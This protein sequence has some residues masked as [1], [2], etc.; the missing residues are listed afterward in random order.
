MKVLLLSLTIAITA[1]TS[2]EVYTEKRV[3]TYPKGQAPHL[4]EMYLQPQPAQQPQIEHTYV[5]TNNPQP[6]E[7]YSSLFAPLPEQDQWAN[8]DIPQD[9]LY[10]LERE[11]YYLSLMAKNKMLRGI[12]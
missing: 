6:A 9:N 2:K 10:D 12:Q 5:G 7:D 8:Q 4:K 1:C 11:N 3:L